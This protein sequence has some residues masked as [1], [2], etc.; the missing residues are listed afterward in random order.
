MTV[1]DYAKRTPVGSAIFGAPLRRAGTR[2]RPDGFGLCCGD[3]GMVSAVLLASCPR[4]RLCTAR[5]RPRT[6]KP[7]IEGH[8]RTGV[9]QDG[10][11]CS[12]WHRI[13]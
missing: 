2:K 9:R 6:Y 1:R 13:A 4:K 11:P 3:N 5:R 10:N 7:N 8:S 12:A